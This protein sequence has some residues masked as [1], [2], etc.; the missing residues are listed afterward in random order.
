MPNFSSKKRYV[1]L[2]A[3][4]TWFPV[5][6]NYCMIFPDHDTPRGEGDI[7]VA[8]TNYKFVVWSGGT[9]YKEKIP[10]WERKNC[11]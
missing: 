10:N 3:K 5:V 8:L 11:S 9:N 4:G 1:L 2:T 7:S 6:V